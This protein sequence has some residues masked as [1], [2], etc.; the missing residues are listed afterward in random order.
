MICTGQLVLLESEYLSIAIRT[1]NR[2]PRLDFWQGRDFLSSPQR[3]TSSGDHT[4]FYPLGTGD[5]PRE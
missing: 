5:F 3:Q 1:R 2:R 4:A